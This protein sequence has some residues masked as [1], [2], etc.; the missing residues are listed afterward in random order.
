M[1]KIV[2]ASKNP[3]KTQATLDG[4]TKMFPSETF[5]IE[6]IAGI[7]NVKDQPDSDQETFLGAFNRA[8][9]ASQ[10]VPDADFWVGLEGGIEIK[11]G[12]METFAWMVI[13]DPSGRIGK[14]RTGALFLPPQIAELIQEGKELGE[15]DDIVF[16]KTNSKQANGAVGLL[17]HDVIT[18][19]QYYEQAVVFALISF[20]NLALY[21]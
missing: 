20:T 12:E 17:T 14:G 21:P 18:R 1:K 10:A 16:G 3:V 15:A 6:G 9:N 8:T 4:F 11:K 19:A 5:T 13:R 2:V 7:S